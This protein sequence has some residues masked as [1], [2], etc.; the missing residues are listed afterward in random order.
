[1]SP[2]DFPSTNKFVFTS[3]PMS[4]PRQPGALY[5]AWLRSFPHKRRRESE[6]DE[7]LEEGWFYKVAPVGD[8]VM[9]GELRTSER[10]K[11]I[12]RFGVQ[13][14]EDLTMMMLLRD[15]NTR[16]VLCRRLGRCAVRFRNCEDTWPCALAS[17][18]GGVD[19][20]LRREFEE[21][22]ALRPTHTRVVDHAKEL[23]T[24]QRLLEEIRWI[25]G[26]VMCEALKE[27]FDSLKTYF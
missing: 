17:H 16:C 6:L 14:R 7:F 21:R 27:E 18:R 25:P 11:R 9:K 1:M 22:K 8:A 10:Y 20:Q 13:T 4:D 19:Y 23:S 26:G 3:R 15:Y 24:R 2:I 5:D 12:K